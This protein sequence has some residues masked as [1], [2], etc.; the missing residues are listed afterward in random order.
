M[1]ADEW[2]KLYPAGTR[3]IYKGIP[4]R[5]TGHAYVDGFGNVCVCVDGTKFALQVR[6]LEVH[7]TK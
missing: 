7:K 2:N 3:V 1:T 5:T 4:M 6:K